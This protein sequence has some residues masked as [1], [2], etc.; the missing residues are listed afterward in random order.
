VID[1]TSLTAAQGF[2]IQGDT[3]GDRAGRSVSSAGDVNGDG[4]DD[5]IVGASGGD[6]GGSAAGEAYVVFGSAS[7]FGSTVGGRQVIDLTSLTA[8]QGFIIQGDVANDYA[9][10][11]VSSAGDVNGDGFDDLIVGASGGD[12]GGPSAGEAYVVFGSASGFGTADGTGRQVID[13]TNLTAGQ[14]FIIQGDAAVDF[15]GSSVSSAGDVNGDGFDDLIVG[16]YRGD[17]GGNYA[18]EAYLVFG[19]ATGTEDLAPVTRTGTA[20]VN[21][22]TGNAGNDTFTN[23]GAGDVVRGGAGNDSIAI[24]ATSFA[25]IRGG[26]GIDTLVLA[27][28]GLRLDLT[29][30]PRPRLESIE[31]IDLTGT[32]NNSIILDQRA[33]FNLTE[34]RSGGEAT[35]IINGNAG[36]VVGTFGFTAN[37]TQL[38][39]GT[40]YNL[41]ESGNAN[42]LVAPNVTVAR[43][44]IV[45]TTSNVALAEGNSGNTRFDFVFSR[46]GD[47]SQSLTFTP[48]VA[49]SGANPATISGLGNDIV[50]ISGSQFL[51]GSATATVSVFVAGDA[52]VEPN[53]TFTVALTNFSNP[54]AVNDPVNGIATGTIIDDEPIVITASNVARMEGNSGTST[55][56]FVFTRTGDLSQRLDFTADV[57]GSGTNPASVGGPDSDISSV[58]S[59]V[60]LPGEATATI[61]VQVRGDTV[62]EPNE[63]F[64]VTLDNFS[65]PRAIN[66]PVNGIATGTI[67][68][69]DAVVIRTTT[70]N[71]ALAEGNSGTKFFDFVF[72]RTGPTDQ[73]LSFFVNFNTFGSTFLVDFGFAVTTDKFEVGQSQTTLRVPVF[74]D[75]LVEPDESFSINLFGFSDPSVTNDPAQSVAIGVILNDDVPAGV[76]EDGGVAIIPNS[77]SENGAVI[78]SP[79]L[80]MMMIASFAIV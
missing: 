28:S 40:T 37:G 59:G 14:G 72:T 26:R 19:G 1:L 50:Q 56:N 67:L 75:T 58:S 17:D 3:D 78:Y 55:F 52:F 11:S 9:G 18:G 42:I 36:D 77:G 8:A 7:G 47:L 21:N 44:D 80:E 33:V 45:I 20:A 57:R 22:F 4:F 10:F 38:V 48:A 43:Q 23:I 16:A 27:G 32:G 73:E 53:E 68:D 74:G 46:T 6:D 29:T 30:T 35:I 39:G 76:N 15:A 49:G 62:S 12:D 63:T 24:T 65:D 25:D 61:R 64:T 54:R 69:D 71:V 31:V 79:P 70:P 51:A 41:F 5:L 2:I 13:L 66:D 60:F 34:A